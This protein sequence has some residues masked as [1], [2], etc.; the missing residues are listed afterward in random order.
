[1]NQVLPLSNDSPLI[2]QVLRRGSN[3]STR[4]VSP[5]LYPMQNTLQ[6]THSE[7][8]RIVR[9][10]VFS[11]FHSSSDF[12]AFWFDI[13]TLSQQVTSLRIGLLSHQEVDPSCPDICL[14]E[15]L[16]EFELDHVSILVFWHVY[17]SDERD[18]LWCFY[19]LSS[20]KYL[21]SLIHWILVTCKKQTYRPHEK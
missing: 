8:D 3:Y 19:F 15:G 7:N 16:N 10:R 21:D 20:E 18:N 17:T 14:T 11:A 4:L 2:F 1:M 13:R 6:Q 9:V 5:K 12:F